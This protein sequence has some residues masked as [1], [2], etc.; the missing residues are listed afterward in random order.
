MGNECSQP[1]EQIVT[2][3]NKAFL[4]HLLLSQSTQFCKVEVQN[5]IQV[6]S[7]FAFAIF[8][9][10][11]MHL[12]CLDIFKTHADMQECICTHFNWF[13]SSP[14]RCTH[15]ES[16]SKDS[17]GIRNFCENISLMICIVYLKNKTMKCTIATRVSVLRDTLLIV[18]HF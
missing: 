6:K 9:T 10:W 1:L 8:H 4:F 3:Y 18:P 14:L 17:N 16:A 7:C 13:Y 15:D 11:K 12:R 2:E 5:H